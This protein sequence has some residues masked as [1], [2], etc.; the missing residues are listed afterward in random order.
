M[1]GVVRGVLGLEG[2]GLQLPGAVSQLH[3]ESQHLLRTDADV[4]ADV[5]EAVRRA[6]SGLEEAHL[7]AG[8]L[9][10]ALA[11]A[12]RELREVTEA[13]PRTA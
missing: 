8:R 1:A 10:D 3:A 7:L 12:A 2:L 9:R 11:Q 4:Q 13:A 5:R 6:A